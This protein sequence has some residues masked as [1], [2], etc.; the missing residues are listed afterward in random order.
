[1]LT[2]IPC[3]NNTLILSWKFWGLYV[4]GNVRMSKITYESA[5]AAGELV[6]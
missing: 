5:A 3:I 1:M 4:Y 2:I 6:S